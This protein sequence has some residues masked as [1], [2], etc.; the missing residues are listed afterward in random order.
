MLLA[1]VSRLEMWLMMFLIIVWLFWWLFGFAVADSTAI[2]KLLRTR[3]LMVNAIISFVFILSPFDRKALVWKK[4]KEFLSPFTVYSFSNSS[5]M[6]IS[7]H[8]TSDYDL[9]CVNGFMR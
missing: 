5:F 9:G 7:V 1:S 4:I 8:N 2:A 6:F 3:R